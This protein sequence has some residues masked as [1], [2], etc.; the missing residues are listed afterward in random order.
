MSW[1]DRFLKGS[2]REVEFY[3]NSHEL[4]AGRRIQDH[5]FPFLQRNYAEDLGKKTSEFELDFFLIGDN[6]D[7]WRNRMLMALNE[8][9]SGELVHPYLGRVQVSVV[10]FDLSEDKEN[11][12]MCRFRAI[13][14]ESG[15]ADYPRDANDEISF[16]DTL[17]IVAKD[18][19]V[20]VF[21]RVYDISGRP[22]SALDSIR[23]T[24]GKK[25]SFIDGIRQAR[26]AIVRGLSELQLSLTALEADANALRIGPENLSMKI[27]AAV[28]SL[29]L[30]FDRAEG[31]VDALLGTAEN[32][33]T[34]ESEFLISGAAQDANNQLAIN[35]IFRLRSLAG[36]IQAANEIEFNSK[37]RAL[38]MRERLLRAVDSL[39][40]A[41]II[42]DG[43]VVATTPPDVQ[44]TL[45][46]LRGAIVLRFPPYN[47]VTASE[48]ERDFPVET[49]ALVAL[50]QLS[51]K[52]DGL[53]FFVT[54]N[55]LFDGFASPGKTVRAQRQVG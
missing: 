31:R 21:E 8:R 54:D 10:G 9:G 1:K 44:E 53:D 30:A 4:K 45:E 36:A 15:G 12:N 3:I 25:T 40:N 34:T 49:N 46:D 28:D 11:L 27:S 22:A 26:G 47:S 41:S 7:L 48:V 50:Y 14:I 51:G 52:V 32:E 19:S 5:Q 17:S 42:L 35:L 20:S 29:E 39:Y 13:F 16:I 6:Y 23:E 33:E 37:A 2:F 18:Q 24:I 43:E 55:D 38:E